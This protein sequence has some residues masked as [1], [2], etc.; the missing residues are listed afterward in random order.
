MLFQIRDKTGK[1]YAAIECVPL[2]MHAYLESLPKDNGPYSADAILTGRQKT[3]SNIE[4]YAYHQ[5]AIVGL[6]WGAIGSA[7][8]YFGIFEALHHWLGWF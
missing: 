5:P 1:A 8:I 3:R 2:D 6:M 7:P 4:A